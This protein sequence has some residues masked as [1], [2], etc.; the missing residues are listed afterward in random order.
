[1]AELDGLQI[2]QLFDS[3][4]R[5]EKSQL[6]VLAQQVVLADAVL[7]IQES[8]KKFDDIA[9]SFDPAAI[10]NMMGALMGNGR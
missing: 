10:A 5:I 7:A 3:L 9:E 2:Q 8:V 6:T 1:M 4:D